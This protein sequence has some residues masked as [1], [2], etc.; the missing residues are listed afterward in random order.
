MALKNTGL[1]MMIVACCTILGTLFSSVGAASAEALRVQVLPGNIASLYAYIGVSRGFY[2]KQGLDVELI[3]MANGPQANSA[4]VSRSV[5]VTMNMPDNMILLK[6]R[7]VDT[8]AVVGNAVQYPFFLIARND[9]E[10]PAPGSDYAAVLKGLKSRTVGVYGLGSS[11]DRFVRQLEIGADV[12]EDYLHR[13]PMGGPAQALA[14]LMTKK[15]DAVADVFSTGILLKQLGVG[16]IILDC[17]VSKC[18]PSIAQGG[19]MSLAYFVT[20]SYLKDHAATLAR[21]VRA[22]EQ[23][24]AWMRDPANRPQFI[25]ELKK[26][27]PAPSVDHPEKYYEAV[28][29]RSLAFF[30]L[31][32]SLQALQAIQ[33]GLMETK[34]LPAPMQLEG[35]IWSEAPRR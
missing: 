4:L 13:T 31:T 11:T 21:F 1:K 32:V 12:P 9:V 28:A 6:Q 30:G 2:K 20:A 34:E 23:I 10:S 27:L 5:D 8:V 15:L 33:Q 3:S 22:H 24:D 25:A 26:M 7:G 35:M 19:Q 18:P 17:S 29:D 16:R 14:G